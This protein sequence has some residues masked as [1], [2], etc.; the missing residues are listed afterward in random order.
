[1]ACVHLFY[2][3]TLSLEA[4]EISDMM[5]V[6]RFTALTISFHG[7]AGFIHQT[8]TPLRLIHRVADQ[9]F[10]FLGSRCGALCQVAH[11]CRHHRKAASL[12]HAARALPPPHSSA[13]ILVW[14]A[15]RRRSRNNVDVSLRELSLIVAHSAGPP[16]PNLLARLLPRSLSP[17]T[18]WLAC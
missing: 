1:M 15:D 12:L 11:F 16:C 6:T 4:A 8:G 13:R 10:D 5:S 2:T 18:S 3:R 7:F 14:K 9:G 17:L